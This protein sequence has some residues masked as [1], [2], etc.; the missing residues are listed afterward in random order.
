MPRRTPATGPAVP[1]APPRPAQQSLVMGIWDHIK[2]SGRFEADTLTLERVGSLPGKREYRRFVGDHTLPQQDI[3]QQRQFEDRVA[4]GRWSVDLHPVAGMYA[5]GPGARQR[6]ADGIFHIPLRCLYSV[7]VDNLLFAGRNI[8]ATHIAFGATR[9][10]ATCA[11]YGEAAGTAA[12]LCVRDGIPPPP[13]SSPAGDPACSPM[14]ELV[15]H[16]RLQALD[17]RDVWRTVVTERDNRRHRV[18]R[19]DGNGLRGVRALRL[20]VDATHGARHARVV[21]V[22]AY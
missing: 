6:H 7:D 14:P 8:S 4:F 13:D 3:L 12:A 16:Y 17:A 15:R 20:R 2:N 5:E 21:A 9:V 18:H 22:R 19:F 10:M 11:T 1:D